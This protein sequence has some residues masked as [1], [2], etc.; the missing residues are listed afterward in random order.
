MSKPKV[1]AIVGPT[2][3]G[4]SRLAHALALELQS[5]IVSADSRLVYKHMN[6]GTA[7]PSMAEMQ[8]LPYHLV[9]VVEP[10]VDFSLGKYLNNAEPALEKIIA[11]G[12]VPVVVG[13]T[14]F[15]FRGLLEGIKFPDVPPDKIF[16][17]SL[18]E[19][20]T[21][22]LYARL[23]NGDAENFWKMHP[24]DRLRIIRALELER[25]GLIKTS[26]QEND[27]EVFWFGLNFSSRESLR[28]RIRERA[29]LMLKMGLVDETEMLLNKYGELELFA[30][31]IGYAEVLRYLKK[32]TLDLLEE[33]TISTAQY[34]K[35][36]MTWFNSNKKVVW[37]SA[38]DQ[39]ES[40][41]KKV[42]D[43]IC[44]D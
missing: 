24:N 3:S 1:I 12:K 10:N 27:Y 16:R 30:K 42:K 31:T 2:A 41:I 34:S 35:R 13:G 32:E 5:E 4:K 15:Y 36:Q 39:L 18:Q 11:Q 26:N 43:V 40:S 19:V 7:K 20:S 37:L 6:I 38:D 44:L 9:D 33:I 22:E 28:V 14:G 23:K 8:E 25:A 21:I 17:E 29:A